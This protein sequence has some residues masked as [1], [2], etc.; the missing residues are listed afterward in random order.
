MSS[1]ATRRPTHDRAA[2]RRRALCAMRRDFKGA[3]QPAI[4]ATCRAGLVLSSIGIGTYL[5]EADRATDEA[6]TD[7]VVAAVRGRLQR[8]R[9]RD[10]LPAAAQR[11]L[12][13]RGLESLSSDGFSRDEI[14]LCTKAGF[15]TPDGEMPDGR[16]RIFLPRV[17]GTRNFSPGRNRGGLPLHDSRLSGRPTGSQPPE[18]GRRM[19][20]CFLPAQSG[21]AIERGAADEF[22][23]RISEAFAFLES[24]V[25]GGKNRRIRHWPRGTPFARSPNRPDIFRSQ[26]WQKSRAK[27]AGRTIISV[28]CSCR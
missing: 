15:L 28:S 2:P 20:G 25:L 1:S 21:N 13:R 22:R 26:R 11:A 16:Q 27:S 3:P 12:R 17:P 6:Y 4:S 18:S 8:G 24:A 9:F 7:A 14:V 10:Q 23:R 19:R 5:G